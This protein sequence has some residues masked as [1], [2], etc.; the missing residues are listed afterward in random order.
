MGHWEAIGKNKIKV[1]FES[2]EK[3]SYTLSIVSCD[4]DIL[5]TKR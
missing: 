1:S 4:E 5:K 3:E 2:E